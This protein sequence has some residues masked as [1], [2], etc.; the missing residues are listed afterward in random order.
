MPLSEAAMNGMFVVL[1]VYLGLLALSAYVW[2]RTERG[3][4]REKWRPRLK[5]LTGAACHV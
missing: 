4:R 3:A 1:L 2:S 5:H